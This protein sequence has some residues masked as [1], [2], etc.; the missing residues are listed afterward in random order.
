VVR[1]VVRFDVRDS[2]FERRDGCRVWRYDVPV[3]DGRFSVRQLIVFEAGFLR[4]VFLVLRI[5]EMVL[6]LDQ[7]CASNDDEAREIR[8]A[9]PAE[10][11]SNVRWRTG[12]GLPPVARAT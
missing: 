6:R 5:T 12:D 7:G 1:F 9:E 8:R 4:D 3:R 10:S 2:G 11:F